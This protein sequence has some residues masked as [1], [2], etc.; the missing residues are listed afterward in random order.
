MLNFFI[1]QVVKKYIYVFNGL[2]DVGMD[3]CRDS[4]I[5]IAALVA[6]WIQ[7]ILGKQEAWR[8]NTTRSEA[9]VVSLLALLLGWC[10]YHIKLEMITEQLHN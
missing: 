5:R 1:P 3:S 8:R 7:D 6:E 10:C 4:A 9:P 2:W